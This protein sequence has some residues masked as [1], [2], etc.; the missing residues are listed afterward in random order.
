VLE[1]A[2]RVRCDLGYPIIVSPFAHF[3]MTQ[4]VLNVMGK[5]RYA[6][7]PD[8]VRKYVLGY[9][10]EI[11]GPIDPDLFDRIAN[12]AEPTSARPGDLLEPGIRKVRRERGPFV[13]DDDLLLSAFY[14]DREYQALKAAGPIDTSYPLASTPLATLLT[15]VAFPRDIP[16][17]HFIQR[18]RALA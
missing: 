4:A 15:E 13:S 14:P 8:E 10:G 16:S 12:G 2:A 18:P 3:V 5:E 7:V 17:F 11:A 6:T 9:Y 1:E